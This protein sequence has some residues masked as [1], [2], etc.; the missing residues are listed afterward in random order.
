M[1][2]AIERIV[3]DAELSS[4]RKIRYYMSMAYMVAM[5]SRDPRIKIGAVVVGPDGEIRSTGYNGLPRGCNDFVDSRQTGEEKYFWFEHAERNAIYNA[6]RMGLS[7][8]R[9]VMYTQGL[10][11]ADCARGVIQ[12]GIRAVVVHAPWNDD[13]TEK[14]ID[15]GKRSI[16]MF[17]EA[18][19]KVVHWDGKL[20]EFA[21]CH[22]GEDVKL[23]TEKGW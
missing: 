17:R 9:C 7:L 23:K 18:D 20:L 21:G 3:K 12:S 14:W 11:C 22:H 4:N 15:S 10:P 6:A 5:Q 13:K 19:V 8:N 1:E 16:E 2:S